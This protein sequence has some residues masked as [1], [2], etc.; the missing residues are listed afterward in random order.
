[1][2]VGAV[3]DPVLYPGPGSFILPVEAILIPKE[4]TCSHR[5]AIGKVDA[6]EQ[7]DGAVGHGV[8][9]ARWM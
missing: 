5:C 7:G 8:L 9:R 1:M 6:I 2:A 3:V 4:A